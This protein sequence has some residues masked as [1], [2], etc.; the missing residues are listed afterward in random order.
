MLT[1]RRNP[2]NLVSGVT[3]SDVTTTDSTAVIAAPG[4]ACTVYITDILVTNGHATQATRVDILD[5]ST[6][7]WT[8]YAAAA[9]GGFSQKLNSPLQGT[10][11][12]AWNVKCGTA[13][14]AVRCSLS[15]F[16]SF[17]S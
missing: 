12:T 14:A 1:N 17:E 11:N 7:K 10:A 13:G 4:A 15:G 8:G 2:D 16:K 3:A 9:G 6:V 5:G